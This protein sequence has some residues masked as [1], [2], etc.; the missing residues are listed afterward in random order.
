M[1][2]DR[3]GKMQQRSR[4]KGEEYEV[5]EHP[6][7]SPSKLQ[8]ESAVVKADKRHPKRISAWV[9]IILLLGGIGTLIA[10]AIRMS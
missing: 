1:E 10:L 7:F 3:K 9:W 2:R 6:I 8:R 4:R 5:Y